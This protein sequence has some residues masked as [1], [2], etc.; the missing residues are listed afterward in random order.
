MSHYRLPVVLIFSCILSLASTFSYASIISYGFSGV[1]ND[2]FGSYAIGT[3]FS[4]SFS[5]EQFQSDQSPSLDRGDY[6]YANISLT[7][8]TD[9]VSD[10][11]PGVINVYDN[12]FYPTDLFHL[13]PFSMSGTVGGQAL[14]PG[15]G[16]QLVLQDVAGNAFSDASLPG[17]NLSMAEFSGNGATFIELRNIDGS[18]TAR[19]WLS[20]TS[21]TAVPVP[22]SFLL[23]ASGFLALFCGRRRI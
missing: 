9:F 19:G 10:N 21:S 22:G 15:A 23:L 6:S 1:L 7:I 5:Y 3:P 16:L 12:S 13:Y 14:A 20:G 17:S 18:Q 11:G 2:P 8:G 4:G